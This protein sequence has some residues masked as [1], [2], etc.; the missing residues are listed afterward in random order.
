MKKEFEIF[1][2]KLLRYKEEN[3]FGDKDW[4]TNMPV[5]HLIELVKK[6][7]EDFKSLQQDEQR[8]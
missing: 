3:R 8:D 1:L 4:K 7:R 2:E 6:T 5:N